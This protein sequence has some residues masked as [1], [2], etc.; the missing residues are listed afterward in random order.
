MPALNIRDVG[1]ERKRQLDEEARASQRS[2]AEIVRRY[3]D[4][5]LA[6][7]RAARERAAWATAAAP[8]LAHEAARLAADGPSFT[9]L[10][11]LPGTADAPEA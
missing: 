11:T 1:A 9:H 7:D 8:G 2:T 10:R 4:E 5:G 6:R 3:I